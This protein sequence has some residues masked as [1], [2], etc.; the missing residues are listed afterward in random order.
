MALALLAVP[1][2]KANCLAPCGA[3]LSPIADGPALEG[4]IVLRGCVGVVGAVVCD[5]SSSSW[6]A[7]NVLWCFLSF[8]V[9][10][11]LVV[12]CFVVRVAMV[13]SGSS[14]VVLL[15]IRLMLQ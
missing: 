3:G 9:G 2:A 14:L 7:L 15:L 1:S 6:S 11:L 8:A 12:G 5:S 4:C 13:H 10:V